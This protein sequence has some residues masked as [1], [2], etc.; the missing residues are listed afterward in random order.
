MR[1]PLTAFLTI[2][3]LSVSL[4]GSAA[5]GCLPLPGPVTPNVRWPQVWQA[6]TDQSNCTQNCHVGQDG[7][8][9]LDLSRL[10]IS[11]YFL[12]SQQSSQSSLTLVDAGNA[13]N[14][15]FFQK[16]N[17]TTPGVGAQMPPGGNMPVALQ[18][19]IYDWIEQG[20]YGESPNDPAARD[21]I[22]KDGA[23]SQRR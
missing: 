19:L 8:A 21:F 16:V 7:S 5:S 10:D 22:F 20:A 6:L 1:K 17:C 18:A 14:S 4:L 3:L 9:G 2:T 15:L 23:E 11:I 12:V 13:R